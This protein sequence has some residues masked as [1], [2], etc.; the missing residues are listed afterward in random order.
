LHLVERRR[1]FPPLF[2][3]VT[4]AFDEMRPRP[5]K[6]T[7]FFPLSSAITPAGRAIPL[8]QLIV[9]VDSVDEKVCTVVSVGAS[10]GLFLYAF[11]ELRTAKSVITSERQLF[12]PMHY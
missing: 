9:V 2:R 6:T 10:F 7:F 1:F 4:V 8:L 5:S 11:I 3:T 12:S